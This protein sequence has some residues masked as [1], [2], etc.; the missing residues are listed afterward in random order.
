MR[1][2][3]FGLEWLDWSNHKQRQWAHQY[4]QREERISQESTSSTHEELLRAGE[5]L[6]RSR[7]GRATIQRMRNA[8]RQMEYRAPDKGRKAC[9]FK[10][11]AETKKELAWLARKNKTNE[12]DLLS[13][14]IADGSN[15]HATLRAEFKTQLTELKEKAKTHRE[16]SKIL[17]D[18]LEASVALLCQSDVLLQ[19]AS[20]STEAISEDQHHRIEKLRKQTMAETKADIA[21]MVATTDKIKLRHPG[22]LNRG[23]LEKRYAR[24][25]ASEGQEL[26]INRALKQQASSTSREPVTHLED[27]AKAS[28]RVKTDRPLQNTQAATQSPPGDR[29]IWLLAQVELGPHT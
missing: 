18:L 13:K 26:R 9:T 19:D 8:W 1:Q 6:E 21:A 5:S 23:V 24:P 7:D 15:A 28:F 10:L 25:T 3:S 12:T 11:K 17:M 29:S 14:L 22:R 27:Q 2:K 4:L 16:T 20:L